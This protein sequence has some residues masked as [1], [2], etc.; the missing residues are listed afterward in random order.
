MLPI[1]RREVRFYIS[2]L[3]DFYGIIRF[4][5]EFF[6]EPDPFIGL[7]VF[8]FS[9]GQLLSIPLVCTGIGLLAFSMIRK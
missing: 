1:I 5:T 3:S 9:M 2:N 8:N 4:V 6:R 7:L